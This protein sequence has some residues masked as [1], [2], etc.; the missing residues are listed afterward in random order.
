M[1]EDQSETASNSEGD[2]RVYATH[3]RIIGVD[4]GDWSG[5][6]AGPVILER[7]DAS[8]IE[9]RY[10]ESSEGPLPKIGMTVSVEYTGKHI[11]VIK[12]IKLLENY[13]SAAERLKDIPES[14][15]FLRMLMPPAAKTFVVLLFLVG[16]FTVCYALLNDFSPVYERNS[17]MVYLLIAAADF[18][19]CGGLWY[20]TG[21]S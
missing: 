21:D 20:Y 17:R 9:L 5:F 18:L 19:I 14:H 7:S 3:G 13:V 2:D 1:D 6:I 10:N 16:V 8:R 11:H 12:R 4:I 15:K